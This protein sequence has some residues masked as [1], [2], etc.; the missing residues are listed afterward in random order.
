MADELTGNKEEDLRVTVLKKHWAKVTERPLDDTTL[1]HLRYVLDA[2][3]EYK[4]IDLNELSEALK[5]KDGALTAT[6]KRA[7]ELLEE[8][9]L[10][11]AEVIRIREAKQKER[12]NIEE[13]LWRT[14]RMQDFTP[15]MRKA[16][17]DF[18]QDYKDPL[19]DDFKVDQ[20]LLTILLSE[21][22]ND[23]RI[24]KIKEVFAKSM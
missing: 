20:E 13:A 18:V 8:L 2:M 7:L 24:V 21:D 15:G 3:E 19:I 1:N 11:Q 6:S 14:F 12:D 16:L 4:D 9:R 5:A 23:V 10:A 22:M 17:I